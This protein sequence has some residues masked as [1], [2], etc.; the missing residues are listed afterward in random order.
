MSES[1]SV[2]LQKEC[3]V[4]SAAHFITCGD[5][6]CEPLHGHNYRVWAEVEGPLDE[7]HYVV[8]FI[9]LRDALQTITQTLDHHMLLPTSHPRI[10]VA[11]SDQEVEVRFAQRRW[12]F[13][14][15]EC[16]LLPVANTTAELLAQY[17]GRQLLAELERR[18][19]V[20][21]RVVRVGVDECHGQWGICTLRDEDE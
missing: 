17:I 13:P 10:H 12:V 9:L 7:N 21:P 4:F 11:A 19:G 18:A 2:R 3:H 15:S 20:R 14:R 5:G 1:Y 16:A 6:I 8:D